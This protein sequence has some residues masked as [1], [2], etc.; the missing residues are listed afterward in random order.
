VRCV[1]MIGITISGETYA[2][3]ASILPPGRVERDIVP[4]AEYQIWLPQAVAVR[5]L[6]LR[7][8]ARLSAR[9]Y[10]GWRS[11]VRSLLL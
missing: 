2:V 10:F 6:A 9:P 8:A 1:C 11:E 4:S 7:S 5:L 3:I